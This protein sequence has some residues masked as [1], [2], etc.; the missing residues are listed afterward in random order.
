MKLLWS[1]LF[2]MQVF[3]KN[4]TFIVLKLVLRLRMHYYPLRR[5]QAFLKKLI[6]HCMWVSLKQV[7][8]VQEQSNLQLE[9][10]LSLI[11]I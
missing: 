2:S 3:Y 11:H 4:K 8:F 6:A 1:P 10:E 7:A 5:V 9:L